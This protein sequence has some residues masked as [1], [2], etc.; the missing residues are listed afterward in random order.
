MFRFPHRLLSRSVSERL[1]ARNSRRGRTSKNRVVEELESR[2]CLTN[3]IG[4]TPAGLTVAA[5]LSAAAYTPIKEIRDSDLPW[6]WTV[7]RDLSATS[8]HGN[9]QFF[10]F[11]NR[12]EKQVVVTFMGTNKFNKQQV[13]SDLADSGASAYAEIKGKADRAWDVIKNKYI[14]KDGFTGFSDGHSLAAGM[15]QTFAVQKGISG[16]G[17]NGLPVAQ[18]SM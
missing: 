12:D 4:N 6:G 18:G 13:F 9:N 15:A 16:F 10:V 11:V 14:D 17:Q 5:E 8:D 1:L 7:D 2:I 3:P